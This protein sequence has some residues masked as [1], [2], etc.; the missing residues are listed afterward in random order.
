MSN[1]DARR[2]A[3]FETSGRACVTAVQPPFWHGSGTVCNIS[4]GGVLISFRE[5]PQCAVGADVQVQFGSVSA[6]GQVRHITSH[7]SEYLVGVRVD[8]V[9]VTT[10]G[11]SK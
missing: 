6:T 9:T 1:V 2:H 4:F 5:R 10:A 7:D 8:N 11:G 3:R